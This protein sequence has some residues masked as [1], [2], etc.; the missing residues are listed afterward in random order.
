MEIEE[1]S[2]LIEEEPLIIYYSTISNF[3]VHSK[4]ITTSKKYLMSFTPLS[5]SQ[6]ISFSNTI[7][8]PFI[9]SESSTDQNEKSKI[10][11]LRKENT[12]IK[13]ESSKEDKFN[14]SEDKQNTKILIENNESKIDENSNE[15]DIKNNLEKN[16]FFLGNKLSIELDSYQTKNEEQKKLKK[17]LNNNIDDKNLF[18]KTSKNIQKKF[19]DNNEKSKKNIKKKLTKRMNSLSD[20]KNKEENEEKELDK[21]FSRK[22]K[23]K[24]NTC[25]NYQGT[26]FKSFRPRNSDKE[27]YNNK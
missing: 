26:L 20:T 4:S 17:M 8:L 16:P 25:A 10:S 3:G 9:T 13:T 11:I 14:L 18:Y 2:L 6:E 21:K 22:T 5:S 27:L 12:R 24:H 19:Q 15:S 7:M 1:N 23:V